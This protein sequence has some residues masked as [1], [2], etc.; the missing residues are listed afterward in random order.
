M[1]GGVRAPRASSRSTATSAAYA[2]CCCRG[3]ESGAIHT[4]HTRTQLRRRSAT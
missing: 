3:V 4:T 1:A 2:Q